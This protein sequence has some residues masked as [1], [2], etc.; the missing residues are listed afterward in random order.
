MSKKWEIYRASAEQ[1]MQRGNF[2]DAENTW[3]SA[4]EEAEDL[5]E[6][7]PR[8]VL[9]LESLAEVFWRQRKFHQAAPICRRVLRIYETLLGADHL[10]VAVIANNLAMLYHSWQKYGEAAPYYQKALL[11]KSKGL[12]PDHPDVMNLRTNFENLRRASTI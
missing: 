10:D 7:N 11:I 4:L 2:E 9:T 6:D 12:G 8:L 5:G 3:L 1:A